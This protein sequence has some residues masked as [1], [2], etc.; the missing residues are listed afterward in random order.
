VIRSIPR[1]SVATYAQVAE[2][3]GIARGGRVAAAALK[4]AGASALLPWQRVVGRAG[5][6]RG[7]IA[8]YDP[9]GAARQRELLQREGVLVTEAWT[10]DLRQFGWLPAD[11]GGTGL[12]KPPRVNTARSR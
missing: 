1:G 8:I 3:A 4:M 7:R 11:A 9:I 12:A 5:P 6:T 10:I 2:L